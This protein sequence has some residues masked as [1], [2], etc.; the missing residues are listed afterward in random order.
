MNNPDGCSLTVFCYLSSI[1]CALTSL[2]QPFCGLT[3]FHVCGFAGYQE[4]PL[5]VLLVCGHTCLRVCS[6]A[7]K[8]VC[9]LS[10]LRV[11]GFTGLPFCG[12]AGLRVFYFCR[13]KYSL[14]AISTTS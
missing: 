3:G 9:G 8:M 14:R 1:I 5:T 6:F 4:K 12:F 10:G 13:L 2:S 7:C 11:S